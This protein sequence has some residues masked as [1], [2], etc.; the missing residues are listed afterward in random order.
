MPRCSRPWAA[1]LLSLLVAALA[2]TVLAGE[3]PDYVFSWPFIDR[4]GMAPRGGITR[5]PGVTLAPQ[6]DQAW[7]TLREP[8]LSPLEQDRR[9]IL[10][11]AGGYRTSFDFLETVG[12]TVGYE[13][14]QPYRS[15]GTEYV[16]VVADEPR[17]ISLQHIIVM[18]FEDDEGQVT[19][20][21]VVKH[22]RQDWRHEDRRIIEYAGHD[23]FQRRDLSAAEA[24]GT[25]SQAVYQVDDSPRYESWGSWQHR[26]GYSSWESRETARPLPRREFSVRDDYH[27]LYGTN[28]HTIVPGGWTHEEDNLKV[29]LD[30][31][32]AFRAEQP[33]LAR[34]IGVNRYQRIVEF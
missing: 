13:P 30:D 1:A 9:A 21:M 20:P 27:M 2:G 12:Y 19:G 22:W 8:G 34:E 7:Q 4:A 17:F 11:M 33:F 29:V 14:P 5:G 6:P 23:V 16:Y 18:F 15:W 26:D 28:R 3:T 25:W 10:A 24:A 32:G 31:S